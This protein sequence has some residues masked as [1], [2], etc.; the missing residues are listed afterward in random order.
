MHSVYIKE[1]RFILFSSLHWSN[2][3][4]G[5]C[6]VYFRG[7]ERSLLR[8]AQPF[9]DIS[10]DEHSQE[11]TQS[12]ILI[13][14]NLKVVINDCSRMLIIEVHVL[15]SSRNAI[16]CKLRRGQIHNIAWYTCTY[17]I[18]DCNVQKKMNTCRSSPEDNIFWLYN[19]IM[20]F[21]KNIA[22]RN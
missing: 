10:M 1:A 9:D 19:V 21:D 13:L 8:S 16:V 2:H 17:Q 20:W 15:L 18:P 22:F 12:V 11:W 5:R 6:P 7:S 4:S 14:A 3:L